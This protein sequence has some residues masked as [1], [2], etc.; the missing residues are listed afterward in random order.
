MGS[1]FDEVAK[2]IATDM[3]RRRLPKMLAGGVAATIATTIAG[4]GVQA[5][6]KQS[7]GIFVNGTLRQRPCDVESGQRSGADFVSAETNRA[8]RCWSVG[9]RQLG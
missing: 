7:V 1:G 4:R 2:A 8:A 6:S 3:P 5:E 9:T